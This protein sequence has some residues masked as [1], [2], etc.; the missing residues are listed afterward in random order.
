MLPKTTFRPTIMPC[1]APTEPKVRRAEQDHPANP[2]GSGLRDDELIAVQQVDGA[3]AGVVAG[4][5][6]AV[7]MCDQVD[8][9]AR[10]AVVGA[11][12]RKQ[13]IQRTDAVDVVLP[14]IVGEDVVVPAGR[15]RRANLGAAV[16]ATLFKG[17]Q[18][19]SVEIEPGGTLED[20]GGPQ[21]IVARPQAYRVDRQGEIVVVRQG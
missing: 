15:R 18:Q 16:T 17:A 10:I 9:Q 1:S 19:G 7:G 4:D 2:Q 20:V 13:R 6:S 11:N 8:L 3:I 12:P 5:Q 14:P 21:A